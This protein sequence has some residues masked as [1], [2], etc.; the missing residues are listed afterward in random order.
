MSATHAATSLE[1]LPGGSET[2]NKLSP[3]S[4]LSFPSSNISVKILSLFLFF[5]FQRQWDFFFLPEISALNARPPETFTSLLSYAILTANTGRMEP[6]KRPL[7]AAPVSRTSTRENL[8][9][10]G[11]RRTLT[12]IKD[13]LFSCSCYPLP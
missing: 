10:L 8:V 6:W 3:L 1:S 11:E 5:L 2:V 12:V 7:V 4:P 9:D 13:L